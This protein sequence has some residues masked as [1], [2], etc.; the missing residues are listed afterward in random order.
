MK[1]IFLI[2]LC[3][4]QFFS[5]QTL[6][7]QLEKYTQNLLDSPA[8]YAANL[9]FYVADERG[10]LIYQYNG[11][12]GLST[13]STQKI[14]TAVVAL[15][16]LG[17]DFTFK[18]TAA[19]SGKISS[20]ELAGDL[21]I[22]SEGDPTLG[23]WRF[24]GFKAEDFTKQLIS[25]LKQKNIQ[26]IS[27]NLII[28][29]T[30][31][32]FQTIPGGW[33]WDD[34]GNYYGAGVWSVNWRENQF[35]LN[36]VG[37]DFKS[38]INLREPLNWVNQ[39]KTGGNSDQSLVFT[40]PLSKTA[41]INGTL[42]A[43]KNNTVSGAMPNPPLELGLE[44]KEELNKNGISFSGEI[45]TNSL[46]LTRGEKVLETPMNNV[47]FTYQS[48]TLDKI[49]YWFLKKSINL[50]GESL[51]KTLAKK[52]AKEGSFTEGVKFLKEFWKSKGIK[53]QMIN[54]ADGSGLSP[55]NYVSAKAEVEGLLY[56][57]KQDYFDAFFAGFP[58]QSNGMKMKSGTIKDS[59]SFAG[60][61]KDGK[62]VFSIIINNY[63]G[64]D[65]SGALYKVLNPLK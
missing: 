62:Y 31:F 25:A 6:H 39:L 63:K 65:V 29:D 55:Q 49:I 44:L 2:F 13:A 27:G 40:A 52:N 61:S 36:L 7:D 48:P 3:L 42:P 20:G 46:R 1:Q 23:S 19:F 22:H 57:K 28:D 56:A 17:K 32:D 35:D 18:T 8:A 21:Y 47:F 59:K 4:N 43:N 12:K 54:F 16:N 26:K 51:T 24:N 14:F 60:F 37:K 58:V 64:A 10:N 53:P 5:A 50:Y 38:F 15:E 33:P 45:I 34:L 41:Y 30:Y 9:S 11:E